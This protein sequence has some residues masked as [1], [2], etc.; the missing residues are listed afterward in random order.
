MKNIAFKIA[1]LTIVLPS[2]LA[3]CATK[4]QTKEAADTQLRAYL[5]RA[6]VGPIKTGLFECKTCEVRPLE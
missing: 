2:A 1:L 3:A 6:D 5:Y 4:P